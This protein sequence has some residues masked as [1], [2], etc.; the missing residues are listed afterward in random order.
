MAVRPEAPVKR[1]PPEKRWQ[2]LALR[3]DP[4]LLERLDRYVEREQRRA[5]SSRART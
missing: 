2:V 5:H 3:L 1:K 4:A